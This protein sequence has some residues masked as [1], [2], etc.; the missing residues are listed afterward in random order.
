MT[1]SRRRARRAPGT[2]RGAVRPL[3]VAALLLTMT[4]V[5]AAPA[6]AAAQDA[7]VQGTVQRLVVENLDGTSA[8]LAFVVPTHGPPLQVSGEAV[9]SV[10][11][12]ATARLT[13]HHADLAALAAG[14][15]TA[16]GVD[17]TQVEVVTDPPLASLTNAGTARPV[18]LLTATLPGQSL[19]GVTP[20]NLAADL[21]GPTS[22][23]WRDTTGS[24]VDLTLGSQISA[25]VYP[26][27]GDTSTCTNAQIL[28]FLDWSA[29]RAG[30]S[31]TAGAD[32][33]TA[34]YTPRLAAC[35][36]AGI[37]HLA[38]GG[39]LWINGADGVSAREDILGHELGHTLYLAHSN[40][41][42]RCSVPGDGAA[43]QCLTGDYGSAYDTMGYAFSHP[44]PL[45][46]AQ[47]DTL[48][49]LGPASA[50]V[51]T[52]AQSA[53]LAP[54]AGLTGT[55]FL[56][57]STGGATYYAEYRGAVG[58][59]TDLAST[60]RGCPTGVQTCTYER[61]QP[62]V[63]VERVDAP[64]LGAP[65]YLL[66]AGAG[67][68]AHLVSDPW[69]VLPV[70]HTFTTADRALTLTVDSIGGTGATVH[71]GPPAAPAPVAGAT[72]Q[73]L[74]PTRVLDFVPMSTGS[75]T[76]LTLANVP[77]GAVAV[78]LNVTA[79]GVSRTSYI[80]ACAFGTPVSTCRATSALN[81]SAGV[82]TAS[83][84][85]VAL[86]GPAGNQVTL[87]NNS[88]NLRLIADLQGYYVRGDASGA[89]FA[90][91]PPS[92]AMDAR[93][94][95][96]DPHVLT[97]PGVPPGA[98]AVALNLT[99]SGASAVSFVSAC[100]AD[101][102][103]DQCTRSS[104]LNPSPSRDMA[105]LV[106]VKLGGAN[107]DQVTLYNNSGSVRLVVDVDGFMVPSASAPAGAGGYVPMTPRRVLDRLPMGTASPY[108]LTL[109]SV[110]TGATAVALNLTATGASA[111]TYVSACPGGT[112]T[113]TCRLT[114][115]FNPTPAADT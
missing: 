57:F 15:S 113:S 64:G 6:G 62:G 10:R 12:G 60:R 31:P 97:V 84:V 20:A 114:S 42:T 13:V 54:V 14:G 102:P 101:Q 75:T 103:L 26:G 56:K 1:S 30:V 69:F 63:V 49:L 50:I 74:A 41:R 22:Q 27:W 86:G 17:V 72:Y 38:M 79:T 78:A 81:P 100:P 82:D 24:A 73:P 93:V 58:R 91:Q 108:V 61:F 104:T 7:V 3:V 39:S 111:V 23:Y 47:M 53:T 33:R 89:L 76:T 55:R 67:D 9:R 88:G 37:A 36:F 98:T 25:G 44:G 109:P 80:S 68:P 5:G 66:D 107:G 46:G 40:S 4:S 28:A 52:G 11:S 16:T 18:H 83:S 32:R 51:A 112:P 90:A 87:Y 115:A 45:S 106:V 34:T 71:L 29:A 95:T 99:S 105:N 48:G 59:D 77:T 94:G 96:A 35:P 92:R 70:G 2:A 43:A 85:V 8:E 65:T 21:T 19:D 110:P